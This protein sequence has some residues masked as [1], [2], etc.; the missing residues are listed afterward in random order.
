MSN[1]DKV[2]RLSTRSIRRWAVTA[3]IFSGFWKGGV[4]SEPLRKSGDSD[5]SERSMGW[6]SQSWS[7]FD[8][9]ALKY[10]R[11]KWKFCNLQFLHLRT[12]FNEGNIAWSCTA[13]LGPNCQLTG[14]SSW[15][16]RI[17]TQNMH[18]TCNRVAW[19][20]RVDTGSVQISSHP[21][22]MRYNYFRFQ[23]TNRRMSAVTDEVSFF[24]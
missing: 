9:L 3:V 18:C 2:V 16:I 22:T 12:A 11:T 7:Y 14:W 8:H 20:P 4:R 19:W 10:F 15:L 24:L 6:A 23:A 1:A 17:L 5:L 21:V 13:Y